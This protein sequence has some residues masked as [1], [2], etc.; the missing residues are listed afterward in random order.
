MVAAI[1]SVTCANDTI[2]I[3]CDGSTIKSVCKKIYKNLLTKNPL[4]SSLEELE[5]VL[6]NIAKSYA[7]KYSIFLLA[8][9][10]YP[11]WIICEKIIAEGV[12]EK[13]A[14][15]VCAE[16]LQKGYLNDAQYIEDKIV[17]N[18]AKGW[19]PRAIYQKLLDIQCPKELIEK[20]IE[21]F[22]PEKMQKEKIIELIEKKC[23]K[24][25]KQ[26]IVD[27]LL[28]KGFISNVIFEV[29]SYLKI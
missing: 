5:E 9:K 23:A 13:I 27:Y 21:R 25:S 3:H 4:C 16:Y 15:A 22:L 17:H 19:G 8:R 6:E 24:K 14:I 29:L 12:D 1:F 2:E 28:R 26:Q 20:N 18:F 7:K 10:A 11:S